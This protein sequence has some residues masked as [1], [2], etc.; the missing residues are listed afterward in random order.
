[1]PTVGFLSTLWGL[2]SWID[3]D[4]VQLRVGDF[5]LCHFMKDAMGQPT[6]LSDHPWFQ[7]MM[8]EWSGGEGQAD[9]A[10]FTALL[11]KSMPL[12]GLRFC[13][14]KCWTVSTNPLQVERFDSGDS[15]T[16]IVLQ[17]PDHLAEQLTLQALL[18]SWMQD[19]NMCSALTHPSPVLCFQLDRFRKEDGELQK[20]WTSL[21]RCSHCHIPFFTDSRDAVTK[22][23]YV[24]VAV[25]LHR[26]DEELGHYQSMLRV[27]PMQAAEVMFSRR[28]MDHTTWLL[29]DD[30]V[31]TKVSQG[32]PTR[33]GKTVAVLWM[34]R[35]DAV[36]LPDA[37]LPREE[38]HDRL[39]SMLCA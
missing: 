10:E 18:D 22:I 27:G 30:G 25:I 35:S 26:G 2:L 5:S 17:F 24:V 34:C 13:W 6:S 11:L 29:T 28:S 8:T 19:S 1:M 3:F 7:S 9:A 31:P 23:A 36:S 38:A 21:Q 32:W 33:A 39:L 16:P 14:E 37:P 12:Q 20:I 4:P 15:L